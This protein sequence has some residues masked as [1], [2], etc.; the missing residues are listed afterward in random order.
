MA[1][2]F[3]CTSCGRNLTQ[4]QTLY[5]ILTF[6]TKDYDFQVL[7]LYLTEKEL[8]ACMD[9]NNIQ[10]GPNAVPGRRKFTLPYDK[11][12]NY[13]ANA[14]NLD[15]ANVA[16]LK[17][18]DLEE[19]LSYEPPQAREVQRREIDELD[20]DKSELEKA[21]QEAE[22]EYQAA[23]KAEEERL[24][25]ERADWESS[26][27]RFLP[28]VKG[29]KSLFEE[30]RTDLKMLKT[31][32]GESFEIQLVLNLKREDVSD[33]GESIVVGAQSFDNDGKSIRALNNHRR[34]P[35]CGK[36]LFVGAGT[37]P[38]RTVVF[39]GSQRTGKTS[40]ILAGAHYLLKSSDGSV[41]RQIWKDA[42]PQPCTSVK[43]ATAETRF[44]QELKDFGAGFAPAKTAVDA[45]QSAS[46]RGQPAYSVTL[47]ITDE[48][49]RDTFLSMMDVPGEITDDN[50]DEIDINRIEDGFQVLYSS[51]AYVLCFEHQ[52]AR[53]KRRKAEALKEREQLQADPNNKNH[54]RSDAE[55]EEYARA[56]LTGGRVCGWLQQIQKGRED[57]YNSRVPVLLLFTKC[58]NLEKA[59]EEE[60]R[61]S[62]KDGHYI[63]ATEQVVLDNE[64][65]C[66]E[67]LGH[68]SH[69]RDLNECY[70]AA[71]RCSPYGAAVPGKQD[72]VVG[73]QPNP[74][75]VDL[76][77]KWILCVTG[78]TAVPLDTFKGMKNQ[79]A[80][81][82]A[83]ENRNL[84]PDEKY[85]GKHLS[86]SEVKW[87][88]MKLYFSNELKQAVDPIARIAMTRWILFEN[89]KDSE[90]RYAQERHDAHRFYN[91][92]VDAHKERDARDAARR[93]ANSERR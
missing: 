45:I 22:Q 93:N 42:E 24:E 70:R 62:G 14:E 23:L 17:I 30:L 76:M 47:K 87:Y 53:Y 44:E 72:G 49:G 7:R 13:F 65:F 61:S 31:L 58:E 6:L 68:I 2:K 57:R 16:K 21:R 43:D 19:F 86:V 40:A 84:L 15:N 88:P 60:L 48:K 29:K 64:P 35:R 56:E 67:V 55:I 12:I 89:F 71:L 5:E 59:T 92:L 81:V 78:C 80:Y 83:P 79:Q 37:A 8:L 73:I 41:G 33:K 75:N 39:I 4:E 9:P 18:S 11:W 46:G 51:D 85:F 69:S 74:K 10:K 32:C 28:F 90:R 38:Q 54:I 27:E 25:K 26:L 50:K 82:K 20:Y 1:Y 77:M 36:P 52:D 66:T 3:T 63:F 91:A 34:C